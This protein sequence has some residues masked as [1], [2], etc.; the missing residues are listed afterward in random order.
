MPGAE[1]KLVVWEKLIKAESENT[2]SSRVRESGPTVLCRERFI[3][4]QDQ[5]ERRDGFQAEI[6]GVYDKKSV[7]KPHDDC[8]RNISN[9]SLIDEEIGAGE[10]SMQPISEQDAGK[11]H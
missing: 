6:C 7:R 3:I 1:A 11:M 10:E 8:L 9:I 4:F 5:C 2:R